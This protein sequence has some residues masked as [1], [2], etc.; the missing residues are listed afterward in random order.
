M[1]IHT[2]NSSM[3]ELKSVRNFVTAEKRP[4]FDSVSIYR[5]N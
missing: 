3:N 4:F 5:Y 2:I 1:S